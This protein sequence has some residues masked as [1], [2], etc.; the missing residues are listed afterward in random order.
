MRVKILCG[1]GIH[2]VRAFRDGV[3]DATA[4]SASTWETFEYEEFD[5]G[6]FALKTLDTHPEPSQYVRAQAGGGGVLSADRCVANDHEKFTR[7]TLSGGKLAIRTHGG[8]Y[9][10]AKNLGGAEL[11]CIASTPSTWE[12]FTI[13]ET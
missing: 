9:W 5:D 10:R 11:D 12:A 3:L 8:N 13:E 7:E 6:R 4:D 2:Y 1:D